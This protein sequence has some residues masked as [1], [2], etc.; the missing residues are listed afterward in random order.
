MLSTVPGFPEG[1]SH[2]SISTTEAT[3]FFHGLESQKIK[4]I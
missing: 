1:M 2:R 3:G 4:A